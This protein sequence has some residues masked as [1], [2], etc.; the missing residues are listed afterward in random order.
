MKKIGVFLA[1]FL[2]VFVSLTAGQSEL[3]TFTATD[4]NETNIEFKLDEYKI[5]TVEIE[6]EEFAEISCFDEGKFMEL[7][8]PEL[9]RF[10]RLYA[11]PDRGEISLTIA[12]FQSKILKNTKPIPSQEFADDN[13]KNSEEI[14]IDH[15]FYNSKE[16][17]PSQI[18]EIGEPVI[19]RD[20]RLVPVTINAFQY[21]ASQNRVVVYENVKVTL[22]CDQSKI[23]V[24]QKREQRRF[25]RTFEP[26]YEGVIQ[27]FNLLSTN[28]DEYQQPCILFI[29]H[30]DNSVLSTL[31]YLTTWKKQMGYE[32]H[33]ASTSETGTN[34]TSIKN[35][36]QN[37]YNNWS[38]PPEFVVLV[39]DATGQFNIPTY[40]ET[41]SGYNGEGDHPYSQLEG[42]DILADVILGRL[43]FETI[44]EF[45]IIVSK[46]LNY[47]K[48][49]FLGNTAWYE[50]ALMVGDPSSS[51]PSCVFTKQSIVEMMSYQMPNYDCE[52]VYNG[53]FSSSMSN[54]LNT[55]VSYFNYRGYYGMSGFD[56]N[57]IYNLSNGLMLP[58]AVI[59]TCGT[60]SFA[61]GTSRSEAF[62]RAGTTSNQKGAIASVGTATTGTHTAF[63]NC[64]DLGIFYGMF[65]HNVLNPGGA[66]LMGKLH[67]FNSFPNNPSNRV[68]I[69]S[70]WNSL[71]GDPSVHLWTG[72]PQNIL[73]TY[74]TEL[75]VGANY[76][77]VLVADENGLPIP[78]AWVCALS[79]DGN[80]AVSDLTSTDGYVYLENIFDSA[81]SITLT[82]TAQNFIPWQDQIDIVNANVFVNIENFNID[83]DNNGT[84]TGNNDG[85]IN[86]GENI[87]L[88]IELHNFG[89]ST[90]N[91][92]SATISSPCTNITITDDQEDFGNIT[93]GNTQTS[94]DDFDF[95]VAANTLGGTDIQLDMLIED[96]MGNYWNDHLFLP[97]DG[98]NLYANHYTIDDA[99]GIW[100]PG[101]TVELI[102][103]LF[104]TGTIPAT[105]LQGMLSCNN[106]YVSLVDSLGSFDIIQPGNE[107]DNNSD[108][109]IITADNNAINGTQI[110]FNLLL[111]NS[112]GYEQTVNVIVNLGEVTVNDP[113]G[114]DDYGYFAYDSNDTGYDLAPI[115]GWIEIDPGYGGNGTNLNLNDNGDTGDV[116]DVPMP[117]DFNFYG[118]N[119]DMI[120]VCSNG[121]IAPGGSSQASF[122]NTN[123]PAPHGPNPMIAVYWDDLKMGNGDVF[124]YFDSALHIFIVE[125]S[126]LKSDWDNS[127]E[128]FQVLIYDPDYYSTPSGDAEILMQYHTINNTSV[129]SYG[130]GL[131]HGQ[132]AT[133]GLE[134]QTSLVGLGYTYNNT[135][136]TA[137]MPLQDQMA[138]KFTTVGGFAMS[139][140]ILQLNQNNLNFF[141]QPGN[142]TSQSLEI[143]NLGEANLMY[144]FSKIYQNVFDN[145]RNQGGP[146]NFGYMWYDSNEP[147]GPVYNW[148]D[149]SG[150]GTEVTFAHN[151]EGT[152]LMPIGFDF[153][154]Y[155]TT[156]SQFRINPNGWIGFGD[157]N[158]EWSNTSLPDAD[159]PRPAIMPFW[160]DLNP[161]EG[162][163][164]YYYSTPDSLVVWF[165]DVIHF[166]GNYNGTYDFELIIYENGEMLF[167]YR[168]VSGDIDSATIGI[169]NSDASDALL[170]AYNTTYVQNEL[171]IG[172]K[173][174]VDWLIP[175]PAS[176]FVMHNET[177]SVQINASA[178]D[179]PAGV[180]FCDLIL[181]TNDPD[182]QTTILPVQMLVSSNYPQIQLSQDNIDFGTVLINDTG[183][184][185][186]TVTNIGNQ[187]LDVLNISSSEPEFLAGPTNFALTPGQSQEVT[188]EFSPL[189]NITYDAILTVFS[190]DPINGEA[191]V[192]LSGN[193]IYPIFSVTPTHLDFGLVNLGETINDTIRVENVGFADLVVNNI[194]NLLDVYSVA[195]TSFTL[196]PNEM[197]EVLV[198][199]SPLEEI[200]YA[201]TLWFDSN[202]TISPAVP[203]SGTGQNNVFSG[204]IIPQ[205]TEIKQNYPNPFNPETI[206]NYSLSNPCF[207]EI[208]IYNI[209]GEK[210]KNLVR[211]FQEPN[212]YSILWQGKDE[213]DKPVASGVYFYSFKAG[214]VN[215]IKKMLLI[216]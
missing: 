30:N 12:S 190:N 46:I 116:E 206:I 75:N 74:N 97:V 146:D 13:Y 33:V 69:F 77:Q 73:A 60:G 15:D 156:Y 23:G 61:S 149:I 214:K 31:E 167:Q 183:V 133:V 138:I 64:V 8:K 177:A 110:T 62:I 147:G 58:Y 184:E 122:M 96:N 98:V 161:I 134:D 3:F 102:V 152:D 112:Q 125:W 143:S 57:D 38:N 42:N 148:R 208:N 171:A 119:Y 202:T 68:N 91:S 37:A 93:A 44:N 63:N 212:E 198:S 40:F 139:P 141:V 70:H 19:L 128:T 105:G 101:E 193:A 49:P 117:F 159:A 28:R 173:K 204:E 135:Y 194:D 1:L 50:R 34:T 175:V 121:W 16:L 25:S 160:D 35:Y 90:A 2:F 189:E 113:L 129:G 45:Q 54:W 79:D 39:G 20:I 137:A 170:I 118:L 111:S 26:I 154:F 47:E 140:P 195:P 32:V 120:S 205:I 17:F 145:T 131:Q 7:G 43:S 95:N 165:D 53:S 164:V 29:Y 4:L 100:E 155:G 182:A 186:F 153:N 84:S 201:D 158:T 142:S 179:L 176:G 172:I 180:Y 87:E 9:P 199:F 151:D 168:D 126:R 215:Q 85:L 114:P 104:N 41:W 21:D 191:T 108:R 10:T 92:V 52:E 78:N 130:G 99:N 132:Y 94:V 86:P 209:K 178:E 66:L 188:V 59:L 80:S 109:F 5:E 36:I 89:S 55:G 200:D 27:N 213:Q 72:V 197:I 81:S 136:P 192:E 203:V 11:V 88:G 14:I 6:G 106:D 166:V 56:T 71:M 67:L 162:G 187:T 163:N 127:E 82:I 48:N 144:S 22:S 18:A 76:L 174:V 51:G 65:A 185:T 211:D 181:T 83:D 207:V 124:Y 150:I 107:G 115:Y 196:S 103:S 24:N 157:D 169:Q 216:K 123:I 210:V